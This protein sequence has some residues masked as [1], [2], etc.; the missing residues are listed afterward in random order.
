MGGQFQSNR[1]R[2][3]KAKRKN[4]KIFSKMNK[5]ILLALVATAFAQNECAT[6][7]ELNNG[8]GKIQYY[9][10]YYPHD[11]DNKDKAFTTDKPDTGK[12]IGYEGVGESV[13]IITEDKP[14][15]SF[16]IKHHKAGSGFEVL[17]KENRTERVLSWNQSIVSQHKG[18]WMYRGSASRDAKYTR[19]VFD[20]KTNVLRAKSYPDPLFNDSYH[21]LGVEEVKNAKT[22]IYR[23]ANLT[24][25]K[26][27]FLFCFQKVGFFSGKSKPDTT[28]NQ[29]NQTDNKQCKV[30]EL[31][32]ELKQ[33]NAEFKNQPTCQPGKNIESSKTC[34]AF[35]MPGHVQ[36]S[37]KT[38]TCLN[39]TWKKPKE[40]I[41]CKPI[42]KICKVDA[43]FVKI[44]KD[45]DAEFKDEKCEEGSEI[46]EG[47]TCEASCNDGF[48]GDKV[49]YVCNS[50][51]KFTPEDVEIACK[52][53][54]FG[55]FGVF[56]ALLCLFALY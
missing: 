54:G 31:T 3:F 29:D 1:K 22:A 12:Y 13:K 27:R 6:H 55:Q 8:D 26:D 2:I 52:G 39:G 53:N 15:K 37:S 33:L 49:E 20:E 18:Y 40:K 35:C 30:D 25:K 19:F 24:N 36:V 48:E 21:P 56:V 16:T 46:E 34:E 5:F 10:R 44:L 17:S 7:D 9:L 45:L 47:E 43:A 14:K 4:A 28:D 32:G 50:K 38:Y 51:G 41:V 11:G 42:K 23:Q